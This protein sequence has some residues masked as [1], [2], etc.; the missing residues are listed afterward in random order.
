MAPP[1]GRLGSTVKLPVQVRM[2][3]E[4]IAAVDAFAAELSQ[5]TYGAAFSRAEALRIAAMEWLKER[6]AGGPPAAPPAR[7]SRRPRARGRGRACDPRAGASGPPTPA[8]RR[9][10]QS[11][12]ADP[13][14]PHRR[15]AA[16]APAGRG[17]PGHRFPP[18]DRRQCPPWPGAAGAGPQSARS[19]CGDG[20]GARGGALRRR[21]GLGQAS[22]GPVVSLEHTETPTVPLDVIAV[23]FIPIKSSVTKGASAPALVPFR[24]TQASF[25]IYAAFWIRKS[26]WSA[27]PWSR[28][29]QAT[30]GTCL[31]LSRFMVHNASEAR[32]PPRWL[33][34]PARAYGPA[35]PRSW[36]S[37]V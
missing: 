10:P 37:P 6:Q 22:G 24:V 1:P 15:G 32:R 2:L 33:M 18:G 7:A 35:R 21:P 5:Q 12:G 8:S 11:V 23:E 17:A 26:A 27:K 19:L 34:D 9:A 31:S 20:A 30:A 4:E 3:P 16:G 13:G 36:L 28:I 29:P 14:G 25:Y